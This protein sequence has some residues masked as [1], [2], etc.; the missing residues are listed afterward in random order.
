MFVGTLGLQE[1]GNVVFYHVARNNPGSGDNIN[2]EEEVKGKGRDT[3]L[4]RGGWP[5]VPLGE[6]R[7]WTCA[8]GFCS[9]YSC[10][11]CQM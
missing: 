9:R 8:W 3:G 2:I 1:V 11:R 6:L 4:G 7:R 5:A 10:H